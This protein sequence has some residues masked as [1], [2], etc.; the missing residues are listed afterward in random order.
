MVDVG[1]RRIYCAG[2]IA[3]AYTE[4]GGRSY[5]FGK[6]HPPIYALAPAAARRPARRTSRRPDEIL[7]LGDGIG[8]DILGAMGEGLDSLFITGGL[9]AGE[10]GTTRRGRA[11]SG[12]PR[13]R[14]SAPRGCRRRWRWRTSASRRAINCYDFSR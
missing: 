6:P 10:T 4:A 8:T 5:Y 3:A 12:P 11:R 13:R 7:C 1:D 9:A 2:A 14:F